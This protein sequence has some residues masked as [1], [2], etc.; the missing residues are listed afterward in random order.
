MLNIYEGIFD[1]IIWFY[2]DLFMKRLKTTGKCSENLS[3]I[4]KNIGKLMINN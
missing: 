3:E 1:V 2:D 4:R